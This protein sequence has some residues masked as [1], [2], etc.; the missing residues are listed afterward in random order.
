MTGKIS[1]TVFAVLPAVL[2]AA[3]AAGGLVRPA[4][5]QNLV[6]QSAEARMQLDFHVPD[7]ALK[8]MLPAGVEPAIAVTGAAK[9]ANLRMIFIDRIAVTAPDGAP[10]G[11]GQ[12][13]YL[14]VP[15]KQPPTTTVAQMLIFGLTGDPKEA[16]GPFGVYQLATTH[17]M[18]RATTAGA[19][20]QV[21]ENWDFTAAGGEH[22]ELH[23]KYD[24]GIGRKASNETKFF[25][26]VNPSFYQIFKVDQNLDIMRNATI[27]VPDKVK[28]FQYKATGGKIAALF[29]GTERVLS[30]DCLSWYNRA[31]YLP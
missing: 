14:A 22:M 8:A 10:A 16:P 1:A 20:A 11:S 23:L 2:L 6:E 26:S 7:A 13:V 30:I 18:E 5:A 19:Q 27:T 4:N 29:D 21:T 15:I 12:M 3:G 17:H 25:S 24:R 31:I 9:D 28:E